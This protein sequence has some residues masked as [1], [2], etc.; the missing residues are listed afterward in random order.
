[1]AIFHVSLETRGVVLLCVLLLASVTAR[2]LCRSTVID[3]VSVEQPPTLRHRL[4][5]I[6]RGKNIFLLH[7]A[8]TGGST[9]KVFQQHCTNNTLR[10]N[11]LNFNDW[12]EKELP[13]VFGN[14]RLIASHIQSEASWYQTIGSLT[15]HA[16]VIF[17]VRS[18]DSWLISA[19]LYVAVTRKQCLKEP[20]CS[21]KEHSC[22]IN[23]EILYQMLKKRPFELSLH[24]GLT[25]AALARLKHDGLLR[26]RVFLLDLRQLT[27]LHSVIA[28]QLCPAVS[29]R[30]ENV[31]AEKEGLFLDTDHDR[32]CT[33]LSRE[34]L[35][36]Q[37]DVLSILAGPFL[38]WRNDSIPKEVYEEGLWE[39]T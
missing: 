11:F 4:A 13:I 19:M 31:A 29:S 14:G 37:V 24:S 3:V 15:E 23:F 7:T 17:P 27:L 9:S 5:D 30:P 35:E 28:S 32:A 20:M 1:M 21:S 16:V 6:I 33:E 12:Q 10:G 25:F 2:L 26:A 18:L 39:Y 22:V 34:F 8:K 38:G 36:C